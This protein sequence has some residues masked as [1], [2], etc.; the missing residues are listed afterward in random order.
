M[1]LSGRKSSELEMTFEKVFHLGRQAFS[2]VAYD[3]LVNR[4]TFVQKPSIWLREPK[5][6]IFIHKLVKSSAL[7]GHEYFS[8]GLSSHWGLPAFVTFWSAAN[9]TSLLTLSTAVVLPSI[10]GTWRKRC[11]VPNALH[12]VHPHVFMARFTDC[13]ALWCRRHLVAQLSTHHISILFIPPFI[14]HP[15][16]GVVIKNLHYTLSWWLSSNKSNWKVIRVNL[17]PSTTLVLPKNSA[18]ISW[19]T[20]MN[21]RSAR[22]KKILS[23]SFYKRY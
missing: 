1:T 16:P 23:L 20:K 3:A 6:F 8:N 9:D 4:F 5:W 12:V 13:S 15:A 11:F 21:F 2:S 17:F 14:T 19:E 10:T 18:A 22:H 7:N